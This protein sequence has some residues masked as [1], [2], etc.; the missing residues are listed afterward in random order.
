[1]SQKG[2]TRMDILYWIEG[3]NS[4][5]LT[6]SL[7]ILSIGCP[8][9]LKIL[10]DR[11]SKIIKQ[12]I[13]SIQREMEAG[14]DQKA[15]EG[16][17]NLLDNRLFLNKK[18]QALLYYNIGHR[19]HNIS[20]SKDKEINLKQALLYYKEAKGCLYEYK[21]FK[22]RFVSKTTKSILCLISNGSTHVYNDY[23]SIRHTKLYLEEAEKV[24][25]IAIEIA[26]DIHDNYQL[27]LAYSNIG[28]L[29]RSRFSQ[30]S[31]VSDID[32]SIEYSKKSLSLIDKKE[33]HYDYARVNNNLANALCEKGYYYKCIADCDTA[34][35]ILKDTLDSFSTEE[36][37]FE[38]ARGCMNLGA[39]YMK[40]GNLT[41]KAEYFTDA[42]KYNEIA[43]NLF[44]KNG[45][46]LFAG[47]CAYNIEM[48]YSL[49]FFQSTNTKDLC[50]AYKY[51]SEA[52]IAINEI[53]DINMIWSLYNFMMV[54]T[55]E[56]YSFSKEDHYLDES[57]TIY[58]RVRHHYEKIGEFKK[59]SYLDM[60]IGQLYFEHFNMTQKQN[61]IEESLRLFKLA[62]KEENLDA[63]NQIFV[64]IEIAKIQI[65]KGDVDGVVNQVDLIIEAMTSEINDLPLEE[66][67]AIQDKF[68]HH[69]KIFDHFHA[70]RNIIT[71]IKE[72]HGKSM[73]YKEKD[74][75]INQLMYKATGLTNI[76]FDFDIEIIKTIL[77][78]RGISIEGIDNGI[79]ISV[80]LANELGFD[81]PLS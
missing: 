56:M 63:E 68:K 73:W 32:Q 29:Y 22:W 14:L 10:F 52:L 72:K 75:I 45:N 65:F 69:G 67:E 5:V 77:Q 18:M 15:I 54:I 81:M 79:E 21:S 28:M 78:Q 35:N 24:A 1:M 60:T 50:K 27:A 31:V 66:G 80:E 44:N 59:M 37:I 7:T 3:L 49:L 62:S 9:I 17:K 61:S 41:G 64:L 39:T 51:G 16:Y 47:Q 20:L 12:R 43:H 76:Q 71:Y 25:K 30:S 57:I 34:V 26:I 55:K 8:G 6:L 4:N 40:L 13:E 23:A 19:H 42:I 46:E 33:N 36:Y 58:D 70:I 2:W 48:S 53:S 74:L 38:H 11:K